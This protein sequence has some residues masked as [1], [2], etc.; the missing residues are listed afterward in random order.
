ME[1]P[2]GTTTES[3]TASQWSDFLEV[4][5]PRLW[6]AEAV[7]GTQGGSSRYAIAST[8]TTTNEAIT[9]EFYNP[10]GTSTRTRKII[11]ARKR[12]IKDTKTLGDTNENHAFEFTSRNGARGHG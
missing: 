11:P 1:E 4:L 8:G 6:P 3:Q 7:T 10:Q 12:A 2:T 5:D 9:I